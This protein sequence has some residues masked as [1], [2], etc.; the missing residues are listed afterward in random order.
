MKR[1]I[2]IM[3]VIMMTLLTILPVMVVNAATTKQLPVSMTIK[4]ENGNTLNS[5]TTYTFNCGDKITATADCLDSLSVEWS[6]NQEHCDARGFKVNSKGMAILA[7]IWDNEGSESA[8]ISSDPTK[9]TVEIPDTFKAGSTHTLLFQGVGA[10]DGYTPVGENVTYRSTTGWV[11]IKF[12]I[13]AEGEEITADVNLVQNNKVVSPSKEVTAK[14][15]DTLYVQGVTNGTIEVLA[16][17]WNT[18]AVMYATNNL[19]KAV[20]PEGEVGTVHKLQ[21]QLITKEGVKSE[22]KKYSVR[23]VD[24]GVVDVT[25]ITV[26]VKYDGKVVSTSKT[27]EVDFGDELTIIAESDNKVSKILYYWDDE[28]EVRVN[29]SSATVNI[30]DDF[31]EGSKHYLYV[32]AIDADGTTTEEKKYTIRIS[33]YSYDDD[34][35]DELIIEPW[36]KE[37]KDLSTLAVSLRTDSEEDKA[38]KNIYELNEEVIYY[39]DYKNGGKDINKKVSLILNVPETFKVVSSDG[40]SVSSSKGTIT[41]TFKGLEED[42]SGTKT[43]VLKYTKIGSKSV[44]YKVIK[45]LAEIK[46]DNKLKDS[47]AVM[48]LIYRDAD[49]E[50][51]NSHEPYM[52]GDAN[53]TTFRPNDGIT[54]AEAALVL[55]RIFGLSTSY[56]RN[57][58]D[59]PDLDETYLEARKAIVAATAYG[60]VQGYP[61]GTYKPNELITRAEFMTILANRI[62]EDNDDGFEIK[63]SS[64]SIKRYK[65]NTKVYV[66]NGSYEDEHWALDEVTLLARLNMTPLTDSNK[67][68]KLDETITRAEVAQLMNYFLLR[69]PA[70]TT[71]KTKSGFSDVTKSHKLFADIVE[72]T[73][74]E[75]TYYIT[76]DTKEYV[77]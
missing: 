20:V 10:A 71:S 12:T 14:V 26:D 47:S 16:F 35:E 31:E 23:V 36:M 46:V 44:T 32:K 4:D 74:D 58:Y 13:P 21:I 18:D 25:N 51:K 73:R 50:I 65:D 56:D 52:Y 30:P 37:E 28:D 60:L 64:N 48:N 2:S 6:Q 17:K 39:V 15:G 34:D 42:E 67:N 24:D 53:A 68:L 70:D 77:D 1:K 55:T 33:D 75:H 76:S 11:K 9:L 7:Y 22:V 38:N 29:K 72:A 41:W 49:V 69:A 27:L 63:D 3:L 59:Y 66:V 62:S 8:R 61:D 5:G 19:T 54:R 43:V 40:G 57:T 45:P